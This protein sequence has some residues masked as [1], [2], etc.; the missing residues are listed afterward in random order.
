MPNHDGTMG[1]KITIEIDDLRKVKQHALDTN[2]SLKQLI[3]EAIKEKIQY[4]REQKHSK[5]EISYTETED[6]SYLIISNNINELRKF[7]S[8]LGLLTIFENICKKRHIQF[9]N[10]DLNNINPQLRLDFYH[11]IQQVYDED[12]ANMII[13]KI[14]L[15]LG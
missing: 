14:D 4:Y 13:K 1:T 15:L 2:K 8:N 6:N 10:L 11:A 12:M 9:E 3:N 5:K 7:L